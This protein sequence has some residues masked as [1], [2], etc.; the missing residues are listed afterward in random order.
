MEELLLRAMQAGIKRIDRLEVS[1]VEQEAHQTGQVRG[2][3]GRK[4]AAHSRAEGLGTKKK[5][6]GCS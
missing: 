6:E 1:L 5:G 2:E 3:K 4:G